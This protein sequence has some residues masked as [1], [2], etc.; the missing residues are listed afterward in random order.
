MG[1][2]QLA[3]LIVGCAASLTSACTSLSQVGETYCA[4]VP[5]EMFQGLDAAKGHALGVRVSAVADSDTTRA[6]TLATPT[7]ARRT[8][9]SRTNSISP[10][11]P[12]SGPILRGPK[13]DA[14]RSDDAIGLPRMSPASH[15]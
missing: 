9:R 5:S 1:T 13:P 8:A 2:L 3:A 15:R 6:M 14:S 4:P 11:I 7:A 12:R 10:P